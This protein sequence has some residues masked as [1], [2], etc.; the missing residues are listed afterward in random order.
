MWLLA[1]VLVGVAIRGHHNVVTL[2]QQRVAVN[3]LTRKKPAL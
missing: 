3:V 2:C 1:M